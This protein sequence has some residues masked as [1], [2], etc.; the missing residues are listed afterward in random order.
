M[1]TMALLVAAFP[2]TFTAFPPSLR[3]LNENKIEISQLKWEIMEYNVWSML[4]YNTCETKPLFIGMH[5]DEKADSLVVR[6]QLSSYRRFFKSVEDAR[7][8]L[9]MYARMEEARIPALFPAFERKNNRWIRVEYSYYG[10]KV[11]TY[12]DS[13]LVVHQE[14][15]LHP[16]NAS[17]PETQA[18]ASAQV[19]IPD[20]AH[21]ATQRGNRAQDDV[22]W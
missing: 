9:T 3:E 4:E 19:D 7:E 12:T 22:V 15:Y 2:L 6:F 8:Q 17:N 21:H 5:F 1:K 10:Y 18:G 16:E 20:V 11:A 13:R 14:E